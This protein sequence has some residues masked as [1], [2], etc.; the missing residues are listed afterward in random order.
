MSD[1]QIGDDCMKEIGEYV[2][3]NENMQGLYLNN[4]IGVTDKGVEIL[5][6]YLIGNSKLRE[7]NLACNKGVTEKSVPLLMKTIEAS[8]IEILTINSTSIEKR[9]ALVA[10]LVHNSIKHGSDELRLSEL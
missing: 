2:K 5:S 4:N 3:D 6:E 10:S 9:N 8:R 7:L 1:N